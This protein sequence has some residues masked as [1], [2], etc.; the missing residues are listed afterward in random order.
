[1][2]L[3]EIKLHCNKKNHWV[4]VKCVVVFFRRGLEMP[5]LSSSRSGTTCLSWPIDWWGSTRQTTVPSRWPST[6]T[7]SSCPYRKST[8]TAEAKSDCW[9]TDKQGHLFIYK[10][11]IKRDQNI[12][13]CE[14][15]TCSEVVKGHLSCVK[16]PSEHGIQTC[17]RIFKIFDIG[18]VICS[19]TYLKF[20]AALVN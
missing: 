18:L 17:R 8:L 1:M 5:S 3:L 12:N 16:C 20:Y 10:Y 9:S 13:M 4:L 19:C 15:P 6:P 11:M 7:T 14:S 2:Y